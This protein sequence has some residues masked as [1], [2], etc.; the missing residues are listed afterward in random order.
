MDPT[1]ASDPYIECW[2]PDDQVIKTEVV[3]QTNNPLY[4]ETKEFLSEFNEVKEAPPIMLIFFDTDIG[5]FESSDD[6]MGRAV[7]Y[8]KDVEDLSTDDRI[9]VPKWYPVKLG[10]ND[11][12]DAENGPRVLAS[13]ACVE[14]DYDFLIQA[15]DVDLAEKLKIP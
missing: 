12:H 14:Y 8:L 13:F 6:Y 7:I 4:Y 2:T 11:A 10:F 3:E 1:G 15:D 9:P 5:W